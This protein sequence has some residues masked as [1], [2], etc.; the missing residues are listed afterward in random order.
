MQR[1]LVRTDSSGETEFGFLRDDANLLVVF[2]TDEADCSCAGHDARRGP[3]T[4][5]RGVLGMQAFGA[6]LRTTDPS[7]VPPPTSM[8]WATSCR[9]RT[10]C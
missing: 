5:E 10:P 4:R 7:T 3:R 6:P 1:A 2:V 8:C 9:V